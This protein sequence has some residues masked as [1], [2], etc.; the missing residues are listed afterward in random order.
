MDNAFM[1]NRLVGLESKAD[2]ASNHGDSGPLASEAVF[3]NH[4]KFF[5]DRAFTTGYLS[6][7]VTV[8]LETNLYDATSGK[9]VWTGSLES[10]NPAS[11]LDAAGPISGAIVN[12]L[13]LE[14]LAP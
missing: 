2:E 6:D 4:Y 8:R 9:L 14:G 13:S 11:V 5:N 10:L 12:S 7:T 1:I 3:F